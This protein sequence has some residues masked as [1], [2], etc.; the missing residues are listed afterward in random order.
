M[1]RITSFGIKSQNIKTI[2]SVSFLFTD[3]NMGIFP[4]NRRKIE[5]PSFENIFFYHMLVLSVGCFCSGVPADIMEMH[6]YCASS[7]RTQ[8]AFHLNADRLLSGFAWVRHGGPRTPFLFW[9]TGPHPS[10]LQPPAK[11]TWPTARCLEHILYNFI[12]VIT[13]RRV[14]VCRNLQL[15]F[16]CL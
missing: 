7:L 5:L 14:S 10:S 11:Q 15:Y 16:F 12:Y 1:Q 9:S 3:L 13:V 2:A 6:L 8:T 4:K